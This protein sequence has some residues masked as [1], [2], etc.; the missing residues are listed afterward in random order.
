MTQPK[1]SAYHHG[2]LRRGLVTA[3]AEVVRTQ[4]VESLTLREVGK[5]AGVSHTAAHHHFGD[6]DGLLAALAEEGFRMLTQ[7]MQS[8]RASNA[9]RPKRALSEVGQSYVAFALDH[10][11]HFRVMFTPLLAQADR[12]PQLKATARAAFG[13]LLGA[14][15]QTD[16]RQHAIESAIFGWALSHGLA[17]LW[18]DGALTE[19][20]PSSPTI[21]ALSSRLMKQAAAAIALRAQNPARR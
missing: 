10:P 5:V 20:P 21:A 13:E 19:L 4:G 9:R 1:K 15:E 7:T 6:K 3:A 8:A 2:D 16:S 18:L 17:M 11:G 14:V 12:Y